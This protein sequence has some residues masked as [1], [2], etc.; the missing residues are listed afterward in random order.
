MFSRRAFLRLSAAAAGAVVV[1]GRRAVALDSGGDRKKALERPLPRRDLGKTGEKV[2]LLGLGC[3]YLGS[4]RD[5]RQAVAVI[6]RAFDLGVNWFDTAPSYNDGE[7]ERRVGKALKDVRDR[8]LIAT[9]S[10]ERAGKAAAAELEASLKRL[11]TDRVDLFQFHALRTA[12]DVARIFAEDGAF[13]ALEAARKAGKVRHLGFTGHYDPALMAAVARERPLETVLLPLNCVD[14]H[15]RSFEEGTL[16]A[17]TS[18]GLGVVAMKVF[19]SG[20]LVADAALSPAPEEC[21]RY[22]LSLPV[23][24]AIVGCSTLEELE[25]DLACAK[26]FEPMKEEEKKALLKRTV[27]VAARKIEWYKG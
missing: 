21:L 12:E 7:S 23:S 27:P 9:K 13:P 6:R 24:T 14:R 19:A 10:T 15:D 4:V 1:A 22:V 20:K 3:F 17:A 8:A 16:P 26:T 2:G 5:E 18:R 11:Q 25:G